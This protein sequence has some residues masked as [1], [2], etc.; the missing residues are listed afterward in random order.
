MQKILNELT[1]IL[2]KDNRFVENE[3]IKKSTVTEHA[4]RLDKDLLR[5]LLSSPILKEIFFQIIDGTLIFD[6]KEFQRYIGNKAF[7][8]DSYTAF[9]NKIGLIAGDSYIS[10]SKEVILGW[11]YK[12]CVLEGNQTDP[13][14]KRAEIF[15]NKILAPEEID[16]LLTPKA[17][18]NFTNYSAENDKRTPTALTASDNFLIKGNN[19]LALYSLRKVFKGKVKLIYIDPPYNTGNDDFG[20]NDSFN[21]SSWLTFMKN[22]LEVAKDLL[23]NNGSIWINI[24]DDES[25]YLKVLCDEVFVKQNFVSNI[26]WE[27]KFSPQNDAKWFSDNHDHILVF[28]KNK[29]I[30]RPNLL[31]RTEKMN[32]RYKNP[33]NDPRGIWMSGGLDV[34]TYSAEYDYTITTPSGKKI[35]PPKGTCW[36]V[37]K[38]RFQELINDN[39]IWF[40]EDGKNVPRIKRFLS[41]VKQGQTPVSIWFHKEVGHNQEA[42]QETNKVLDTEVF[43]TPKPERLM[44]RIIH[45]G[46]DEGDLVLDFYAGSGTTAAVAMKMKRQFITIEQMD[47]ISSITLTRMKNVVKGEQGGISKD[48]NWD[49][50]GSFNYMELLPAKNTFISEV[51][52]AK[53]TDDLLQIWDNIKKSHLLSYT[54]VPSQLEDNL[55]GFKQLSVVDQKRILLETLDMNLIYVPASDI[56]DEDNAIS[57]QDKKL[58]KKFYSF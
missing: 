58:T 4:L 34:K 25:H 10:E 46:S 1:K 49:G 38:K 40:G 22:R 31:P 55:Y 11:P 44:Q 14:Q 12:D 32:K 16:R 3:I 28:A 27:K 5:L 21:H 20:Y 43:K 57:E 15:W 17:F 45:I 19:L 52:K 37:S 7:L 53:K 36:R 47:Y 23:A 6:K 29:E 30:W 56:D 24:D 41:E 13:D 48:L 18:T 51:E 8:P 33:D 54:V 42:R 35:N 50:G 9:K 2:A 39:R 26:I